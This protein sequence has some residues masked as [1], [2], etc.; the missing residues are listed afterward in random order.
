MTFEEGIQ[1][2][3]LTDNQIKLHLERIRE[4]RSKRNDITD[5]LHEYVKG[6]DLE[7]ATI[8]ITDGRLKFQYS[9]ITNPLTFRFI[10]NCLHECLET[11]EHVVQ[12]IKFIKAKRSTRL[13][14]DIKRFYN[15]I[16]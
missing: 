1:N 6:K 5:S 10:E 13:V 12:I 14:P 2:W 8:K 9:K 15:K 16:N 4:L 7:N 11:S 3:V